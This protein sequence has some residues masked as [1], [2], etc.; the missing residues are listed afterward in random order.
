MVLM[1]CWVA[2]K[3]AKT[4]QKFFFPIRR[5]A[6]EIKINFSNINESTS[7]T[8]LV[9]AAFSLSFDNRLSHGYVDFE[10]CTSRTIQTN[11]N[12][13]VFQISDQIHGRTRLIQSRKN[14]KNDKISYRGK[15]KKS[16][17]AQ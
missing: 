15:E 17:N 5:A 4:P 11:M 8:S 14:M 7:N 13:E 2:G 1:Q 9:C 3:T 12:V 10:Y 16:S 6:C